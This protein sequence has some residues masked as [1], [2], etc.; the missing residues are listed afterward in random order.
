MLACETREVIPS[1]RRGRHF[2]AI[3]DHRLPHEP[4]RNKVKPAIYG[5]G[6]PRLVR[7]QGARRRRHNRVERLSILVGLAQH[8]EV[9]L[10]QVKRSAA[11]SLHPH[12]LQDVGI[13]LREYV[14]TYVMLRFEIGHEPVVTRGLVRKDC[15]RDVELLRHGSGAASCQQHRQRQN[16]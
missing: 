9:Q 13:S 3:V 11:R 8:C 7:K 1:G 12:R 14:H 10:N 2:E 5:G 4:V 16:Q 6:I 15:E